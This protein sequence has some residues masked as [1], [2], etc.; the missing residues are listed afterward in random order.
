MGAEAWRCVRTCVFVCVWVYIIHSVQYMLALQ[1][2]DFGVWR[3][4][5]RINT[6]EFSSWAFPSPFIPLSI[7]SKT[8]IVIT[9]STL[10]RGFKNKHHIFLS[11]LCL[12]LC[13]KSLRV[14]WF[15]CKS[16][17][18]AKMRKTRHRRECSAG[19]TT[20]FYLLSTS[21]WVMFCPNQLPPFSVSK[22][23]YKHFP[24]PA[25]AHD[26]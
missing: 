5:T 1:G 18:R 7:C 8:P 26:I 6:S 15:Q 10:C 22:L 9:T 23:Q 24:S 13:I 20:P 16:I 12:G 17:Q 21:C 14:E 4:C 2:R 19:A 11:Y 25:T 3:W